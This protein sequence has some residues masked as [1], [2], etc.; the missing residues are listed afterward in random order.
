MPV[1]CFELSIR[2]MSFKVAALRQRVETLYLIVVSGV[3]RWRVAIHIL[4]V[5]VY[6]QIGRAHV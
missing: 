4:S 1:K 2:N 5:D 6:E 3:M